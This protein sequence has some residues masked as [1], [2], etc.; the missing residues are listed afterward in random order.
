MTLQTAQRRNRVVATLALPDSQRLPT[1]RRIEAPTWTSRTTPERHGGLKL[2]QTKRCTSCGRTMRLS[3][4]GMAYACENAAC[5]LEE[6][7]NL[8]D[9]ASHFR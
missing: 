9:P 7:S 6:P 1:F 8:H 5:E 2:P 4:D 3:T